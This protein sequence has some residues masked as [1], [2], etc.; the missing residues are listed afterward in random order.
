[1]IVCIS[2][3]LT[4]VLDPAEGFAGFVNSNVILFVD[5]FIIGGALFRTGMASEIGGLVT[6]FAKTERQLVVVIM[7]LTGFMSGLLSNTGTAAVLIPVIIGIAAQSGFARSR[8]LMPIVFA[9]AMGGNL[10]LIGA[11][12]N[13]IAQA[14]L[15]RQGLGFSF[16]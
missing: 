16:F 6:R 7:L 14:E 11:P 1:M 13:L 8:L 15:Q 3:I 12:G 5:M 2:L 9:A 10:S 4:G